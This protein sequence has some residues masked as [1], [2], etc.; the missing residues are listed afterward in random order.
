MAER[1]TDDSE[2]VREEAIE[3]ANEFATVLVRRVRTRNG[4]RLEIESPRQGSL[5]RL[6]PLELEALSGQDPELFTQLLQD[7]NPDPDGGA[8]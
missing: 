1:D 4:V 6:D 7:P 2:L 3:L 8:R 5:I